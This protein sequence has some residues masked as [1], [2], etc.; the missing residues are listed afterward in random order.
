MEQNT[1][2]L[3]EL[4]IDHQSNAYL[5]E[6]AK[7]AKFLAIVGFVVCGLIALAGIFAGTVLSATMGQFG[8]GYGASFGIM[9]TVM[10]L[11]MAVVYF[12]PCL[13]L[14]RFATRMQVVLQNNDQPNLSVAL[15]NLKSYFKFIGILTLIALAFF[16][17]FFFFGI[18]GAAMSGM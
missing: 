2:N 16:A 1:S 10:Y 8:G 5:K 9:A 13:F 18:A 11:I 6:T 4:Q 14:F 12:F 7:W 15:S 17:L 3:F